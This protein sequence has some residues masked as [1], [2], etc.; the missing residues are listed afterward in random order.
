MQRGQPL[1]ADDKPS[2]LLLLFAYLTSIRTNKTIERNKLLINS[3]KSILNKSPNATNNPNE[4]LT[5][6]GAKTKN[7]KPQDIVRL[8]D[9]IIQV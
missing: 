3:Y 1:T 7:V 8:Y 2:N 9:L 4:S 6:D 5:T